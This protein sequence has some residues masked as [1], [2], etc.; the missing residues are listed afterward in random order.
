MVAGNATGMSILVGDELLIG[1]HAEGLGRLADD[2]EISRSHA[3]IT[4]DASGFCAIEDLGSTNGTF[5]NGLRITTPQTLAE[6]D[7]IEIGGT[8]LVLRE[9]PGTDLKP[10][11]AP[12]VLGAGALDSEL[13]PPPIAGEAALT[14]PPVTPPPMTPPPVPAGHT[15]PAPPTEDALPAPDRRH[16]R[17]PTAHR[18]VRRAPG[19]RAPGRRAPGRRTAPGPRSPPRTLPPR[20]PKRCLWPCRWTLSAVRPG[21][22]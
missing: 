9:L 19:R 8:T 5:V 4:F 18:R 17:T 12:S 16:A 6:G 1:R 7:T 14:P 2:E 15:Y 20:A 11:L 21:C 10:P 22:R 13:S 3:R